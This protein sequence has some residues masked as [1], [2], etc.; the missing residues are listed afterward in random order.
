MEEL[1]KEVKQEEPVSSGLAGTTGSEQGLGRGLAGMLGLLQNTGELSRKNAGKEELRGRA[2]DERTYEDYDD[3]DLSTVVKLDDRTA[4]DKDKEMAKK[5][6]KLEY[7]D[8]YGRLLTRRDAYR[9]L[10]H[11]FHGFKGNMNKRKEEKKL[12][13]IANEQGRAEA[14][15]RQAGDGGILGALKATQEATGKAYVVHKT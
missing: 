6:I 13:Q 5:Q 9:D 3:L 14:A 4:T 11:Q 15:A 8:K 7:R 12:K 10:S 2:R 1:A